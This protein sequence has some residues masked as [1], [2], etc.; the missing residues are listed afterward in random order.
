MIVETKQ[1]V[2]VK[3][4]ISKQEINQI[5]NKLAFTAPIGIEANDMD[6]YASIELDES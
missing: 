1:T 4:K 5:L 6:M 2:T 3:I